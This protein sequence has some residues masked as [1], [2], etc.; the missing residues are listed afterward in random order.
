MV[1]NVYL[2]CML[3]NSKWIIIGLSIVA[4][5]LFLLANLA[6]WLNRNI[7]DQETFR[8]HITQVLETDEVGDAIASKILDQTLEERPIVRRLSEG[9][10]KS[11]VKGVL[12][13][14][15]FRPAIENLIDEIHIRFISKNTDAITI[16]ISGTEDFIEKAT[17]LVDSEKIQENRKFEIPKEIV[18]VGEGE[19]PSIYGWGIVLLWSGMLGGLI[20]LGILIIMLWNTS[21]KGRISILK[22][23]GSTLVL[24]SLIMLISVYNFQPSL[25]TQIENPST[26]VILLGLYNSSVEQL[27]VQT[28]L[29]ILLGILIVAVGFMFPIFR[30]EN[31]SLFNQ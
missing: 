12:R 10:V 30:K 20:G 17:S 18:L 25:T 8:T 13:S 5:V 16:N 1:Y 4:T 21:E 2:G 31:K 28:K 24:G 27:I 6:I 26:R 9:L 3:E 11:S 14:S 23:F 7:F 15:T 19:I 22:I 29:M